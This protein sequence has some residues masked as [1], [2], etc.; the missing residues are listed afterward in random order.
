ME[1][2][3]L[4]RTIA[5]GAETGDEP[6]SVSDVKAYMNIDFDQHDE[7]L[8]KLIKACRQS[9]EAIYEQT[10]IT[11]RTITVAW[12]QLFDSEPLPYCPIK[13]NT[14]VIVTDLEGNVIPRE[15]YVLSNVGGFASISGNF[16]NGIKLSYVCAKGLY[17]DSV[18]EGL[19]RAIQ[20]CFE[21][22]VS[23]R[24]SL[25]K[26]FKNEKIYA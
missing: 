7:K 15:G 21:N 17:L 5:L 11:E 1:L 18:K 12:Q 14:D 26:I 23:P 20:D 3:T 6:V 25:V 4:E 9:L 24:V 8:T 2:I 22:N 16:P 19:L 13:T 10:L